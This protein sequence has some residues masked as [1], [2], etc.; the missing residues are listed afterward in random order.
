MAVASKDGGPAASAAR[1][2]AIL[3]P[4]ESL[5]AVLRAHPSASQLLMEMEKQSE[6]ALRATEVTLEVLRAAGFDPRHASA[7]A[8]STLWTALMLRTSEPGS[9]PGTRLGSPNG[10]L[11]HRSS[12]SLSRHLKILD[13]VPGNTLRSRAPRPSGPSSLEP[14][15][16]PPHR[17]C[18]RASAR[19]HHWHIELRINS[20][21]PQGRASS[22]A[23]PVRH[24]RGRPV[25]RSSGE[26]RA[27]ST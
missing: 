14:R 7:I 19:H 10:S 3:A 11:A 24:G 17:D 27:G 25:R 4:A 15:S 23:P 5:I 21:H 22:R 9:K 20:L 6:P 26:R 18:D 2:R 1:G 13:F 8:R 16:T 12:L